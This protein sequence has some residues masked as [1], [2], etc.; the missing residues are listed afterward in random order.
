MVAGAFASVL[1]LVSPAP[2][3]S[4]IL[5]KDQVIEGLGPS[6]DAVERCDG[7]VLVQESE[8]VRPLE[9]C[10]PLLWSDDVVGDVRIE[11]P[12]KWLK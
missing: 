4:D 8:V 3:A 2:L 1:L 5:P 9:V 11:Q 7:V 6:I 10:P 12:S